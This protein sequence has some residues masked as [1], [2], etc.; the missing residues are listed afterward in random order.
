LVD[1]LGAGKLPAGAKVVQA[2][3]VGPS[4]GQESIDAGLMSFMIAFAIIIVYH[5]LLRWMVFMQ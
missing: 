4:L 5:F 2:T 3:V 1:V